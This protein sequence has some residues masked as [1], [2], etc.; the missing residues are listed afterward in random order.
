M[1]LS[2]YGLEVP[3]DLWMLQIV[4][5]V[6]LRLNLSATVRSERAQRQGD[7]SERQMLIQSDGRITASR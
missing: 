5:Q 7:R 1:I 6:Y 3:H 2:A 4:K